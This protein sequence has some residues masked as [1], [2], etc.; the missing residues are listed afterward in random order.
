MT[1]QQF[2]TGL[3]A[4]PVSNKPIIRNINDPFVFINDFDSQNLSDLG[5]IV[6]GNEAIERLEDI[7][8]K[9]VLITDFLNLCEDDFFEKYMG[10][11]EWL[12]LPEEIAQSFPGLDVSEITNICQSIWE[13]FLKLV[14]NLSIEEEKRS[15][16]SKVRSIQTAIEDE[17]QTNLRQNQSTAIIP[18]GPRPALRT[19]PFHQKPPMQRS[20]SSHSAASIST[21]PDQSKTN[22]PVWRNLFTGHPLRAVGAF[23]KKISR[24]VR[25]R[26]LSAYNLKASQNVQSLEQDYLDRKVEVE[27][28]PMVLADHRNRTAS[29]NIVNRDLD[30]Q[31]VR[32]ES[33]RKKLKKL[34]RSLEKRMKKID[35]V[36]VALNNRAP[37]ASPL[38]QLLQ[39]SQY[40]ASN[41]EKFKMIFNGQIE[42]A[43]LV[44]KL[45]EFI[46]SNIPALGHNPSRPV[47]DNT[48]FDINTCELTHLMDRM[49]RLHIALQEVNVLAA[50]GDARLQ[51]ELNSA[52][53]QLKTNK[54]EIKVVKK[55]TKSATKALSL[56]ER[57]LPHRR[58]EIFWT[59]FGQKVE[60][61]RSRKNKLGADKGMNHQAYRSTQLDIAQRFL[62]LL[63]EVE[64]YE[65]NSGIDGLVA[66]LKSELGDLMCYRS[67]KDAQEQLQRARTLNS[68]KLE[69]L[70]EDLA[71]RTLLLSAPAPAAPAATPPA[72]PAPA[73]Q[74]P[75]A[76]ASPVV[77]ATTAPTGS[78]KN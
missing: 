74:P 60:T 22:P 47:V 36:F 29:I 56:N 12:A 67:L 64:Q 49:Q 62:E 30:N 14:N 78:K 32:I 72:P 35:A 20:V 40:K 54:G 37:N 46:S 71:E 73:S 8:D 7:Q 75:S 5:N 25:Q 10:E 11:M 34:L 31:K 3:A 27:T 59:L 1:T 61:I 39:T 65:E 43:K 38:N 48:P 15:A 33:N 53:A 45:E 57:V 16:A 6:A 18:A 77:T 41:E 58:L 24:V 9:K 23:F 70:L 19:T 55:Q 26:S 2:N 13:R 68:E 69:Y 4:P 44:S 28:T 51:S 76:A 17:L 42:L 50:S 66:I 21:I 63:Q 52:N